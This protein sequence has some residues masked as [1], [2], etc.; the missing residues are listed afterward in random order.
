MKTVDQIVD[1][2]LELEEGTKI[3][4]MA[5]VIRGKKR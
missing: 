5:P 3:L 2:I 4:V 1:Q